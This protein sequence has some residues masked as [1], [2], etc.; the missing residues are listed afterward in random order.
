QVH[1]ISPVV[2]EWDFKRLFGDPRDET[3]FRLTPKN[4]SLARDQRVNVQVEFVP[5]DDR[6]VS[7]KMG[8]RVASTS[9]T[10]SVVLQG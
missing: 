4:G 8:V 2:A 7:L 5:T 1:N 9:K 3:R 6:P 10:A